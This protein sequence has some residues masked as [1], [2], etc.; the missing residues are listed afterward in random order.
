[1]AIAQSLHN[2][3]RRIA[4]DQNYNRRKYSHKNR[5]PAAAVAKEEEEEEE[6]EEEAICR[7]GYKRQLKHAGIYEQH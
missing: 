5:I 6:E 7:R 1:L 4:T 2:W 3:Q